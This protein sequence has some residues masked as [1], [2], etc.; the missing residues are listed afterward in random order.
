MHED[1]TATV[2]KDGDDEVDVDTAVA[3]LTGP[4]P[5]SLH[6]MMETIMMTQAPH[7]QLLHGLLTVVVALRTNLA[8]YRRHIPPS[9]PSDSS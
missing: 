5:P 8:Y 9:P 7:G 6:A 4:H 2:V 1:L 3:A